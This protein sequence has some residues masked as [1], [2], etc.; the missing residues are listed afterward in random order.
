MRGNGARKK[1]VQSEF[2]MKMNVNEL[3]ALRCEF[4][5]TAYRPN[6]PLEH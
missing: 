6:A 5:Y 2:R 4:V 3:Y 1:N